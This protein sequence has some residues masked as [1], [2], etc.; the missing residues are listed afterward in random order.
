VQA[1]NPDGML[2]LRTIREQ[3]TDGQRL[4]RVGDLLRRWC[5][6]EPPAFETLEAAGGFLRDLLAARVE[7]ESTATRDRSRR[8]PPRDTMPGFRVGNYSRMS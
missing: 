3:L 4:S 6:S 2:W 7:I 5:G 1:A 8:L